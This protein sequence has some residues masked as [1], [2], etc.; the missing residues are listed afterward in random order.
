VQCKFDQNLRWIEADRR[1]LANRDKA[2]SIFHSK[3][4]RKPPFTFRTPYETYENDPSPFSFAWSPDLHGNSA[5]SP[6][7]RK[8]PPS[9]H[10]YYPFVEFSKGAP[11]RISAL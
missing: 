4:G 9:C 3:T 1:F 11:G 5:F 10:R 8:L 7:T 6:A 2:K